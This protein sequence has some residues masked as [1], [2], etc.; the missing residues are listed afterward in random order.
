MG[1]KNNDINTD[2]ME[3]RSIGFCDSVNS[4]ILYSCPER[5]DVWVRSHTPEGI[6]IDV[7]VPIKKLKQMI[8]WC[9]DK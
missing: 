9:E 7:L 3:D 4:V 6:E 2:A 8:N 1:N 5:Q